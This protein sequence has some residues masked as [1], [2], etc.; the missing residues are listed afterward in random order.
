MEI[1]EKNWST[2]TKNKGFHHEMIIFL[3]VI[4]LTPWRWKRSSLG[5]ILDGKEE[6]RAQ[7]VNLMRIERPIT[8][9]RRP[10]SRMLVVLFLSYVVLWQ[11]NLHIAPLFV[12]APK[13]LES[14]GA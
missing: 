1:N 7:I 2:E 11:S 4:G 12:Q 14:P 10:E 13:N 3:K 6:D 5:V 9:A 8:I